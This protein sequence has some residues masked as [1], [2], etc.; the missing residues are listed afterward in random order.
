MRAEFMAAAAAEQES[1]SVAEISAVLNRLP[2]EI[3]AG[4]ADR[5]VDAVDAVMDELYRQRRLHCPGHRW[6]SGPPP[7]TIR[8][9]LVRL[10]AEGNLLRDEVTGIWTWSRVTSYFTVR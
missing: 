4:P 2:R 3:L 6:L 8:E 5:V 1:G 7:P 9:H 10:H